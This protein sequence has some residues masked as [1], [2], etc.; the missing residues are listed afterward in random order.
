MNILMGL[1]V[2][3]LIWRMVMGVKKGVAKELISLIGV[4]TLSILAILLAYAVYSYTDE[5]YIK[6][7][8]VLILIILLLLAYK[9]LDFLFFTVGIFARLPVIRY[10]DK[11]L[12]GVIGIVETVI[13]IGVIFSLMDIFKNITMETWM[14]NQMEHSKILQYIYQLYLEYLQKNILE[15]SDIINKIIE[16]ML[17]GKG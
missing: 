8:V 11:L 12:G 13:I 15:Y 2:L 1:I 10:C 14:F 9:A 17:I 4:I 16:E 3:L 7:M 6:I 5:E